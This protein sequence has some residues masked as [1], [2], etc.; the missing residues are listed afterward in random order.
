MLFPVLTYLKGSHGGNKIFGCKIEHRN[1]FQRNT[2]RM[3]KCK[4]ND[5]S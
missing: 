2:E 5:H 1:K 3:G 4:I